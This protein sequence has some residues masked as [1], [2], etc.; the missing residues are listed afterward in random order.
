MR[1]A[2]KVGCRL[3]RRI[4]AGFGVFSGLCIAALVLFTT[5]NIILRAT[6]KAP[7]FGNIEITENMMVL[8]ALCAIPY[9]QAKKG[10]IAVEVVAERLP[11]KTRTGFHL[12]SVILALCISV[13]IVW[14][15]VVET[16]EIWDQ[17]KVTMLLYLPVVIFLIIICIG[18]SLYIL[19]LIIDYLETIGVIGSEDIN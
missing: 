3:I 2:I 19:E 12:T 14:R 5:A 18:L 15:N 16:I 1:Q 8:I 11:R 7:I 9:T 13:F 4:T 17:N 6:I 10:H